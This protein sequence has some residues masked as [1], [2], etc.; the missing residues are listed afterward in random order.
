MHNIVKI[1]SLFLMTACISSCKSGIDINT[2]DKSYKTD[3]ITVTAP[4]PQLSGLS[5]KDLQEAVNSEYLSIS[6][7]LLNKFNSSAKQTGAK[8]FFEMQ[9]TPYYNNHNLLSIVT[10]I[11]SEIAKNNKNS[12]RITK[13]IDTKACVELTLGDLFSDDRYIDMINSRIEYEITEN[14]DKYRDLW[15]KPK[16]S[17]NQRFYIDG[18][19]IVLFYPPY[20]LS[21]YERGFVEIPISLKDMSGYLKSD[22]AYLSGT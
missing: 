6:N 22:Y 3:S 15:E 10:Q 21:Y 8:S 11:D 2:I 14:P 7:E 5:G 12:L 9:T 16:L 20:E 19:N 1:C 17:H 4:I 13:N 18:S